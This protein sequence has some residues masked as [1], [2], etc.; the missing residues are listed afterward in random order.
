METFEKQK[1]KT[2]K[3]LHCKQAKLAQHYLNCRDNLKAVLTLF[4]KER[5]NLANAYR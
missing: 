5:H 4:A 1:T 2:K 3:H